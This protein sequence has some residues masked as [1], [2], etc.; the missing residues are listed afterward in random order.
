MS[1]RLSIILIS[2]IA[3]IVCGCAKESCP[4]GIQSDLERLDRAISSRNKYNED[5]QLRID[6]FNSRLAASASPSDQYAGNK[7][8]FDEY[9]KFNPDSA[10]LYVEKCLAIAK[11]NNLAHDY[12]QSLID[13]AMV[14]IYQGDYY[15]AH[16]MLDSIG[17]VENISPVL[18]HKAASAFIEFHIRRAAINSGSGGG[19]SVEE[20]HQYWE[21]FSPYLI[22]G[23]WQTEYYEALMTNNDKRTALKRHIKAMSDNPMV[24]AMLNYA[25][26]L[27]YFRE[28]KDVETMHYIIE[29]AI[30]DIEA[31]NRE[32][33]SLI[34]L[35]NRGLPY[36]DTE[37][38]YK[39]VMI[40][41]E[42]AHYYKDMGRSFNVIAAHASITNDFSEKLKHRSDV[43]T[44]IVLA[45]ITAI[46][47]IV[48][49]FIKF[50]NKRKHEK[51]LLKEKNELT[52]KLQLMVEQGKLLQQDLLKTNRELAQHISSRNKTFLNVYLLVMK[53]VKDVQAFKKDLHSFL[54]VGKYEKAK[55]E[56]A[57]NSG[58]EK[59]LK[60]FYAQFDRAFLMVHPDFPQKFNEL[61]KDENKINLPAPETLTPE[62]RIYALVSL[63]LTDSLS[64]AEFL[65]Y[66]P[67][68][69]YNYRLKVRKGAAIP[70]KSFATTVAHFYQ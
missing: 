25:L 49:L 40:C 11:D 24:C 14:N 52:D 26:A 20:A 66:S 69:I 5:K 42:N 4:E 30:N 34:F 54:V 17:P 16:L 70:E 37:R 53:Y 29:S 32:A 57:S 64:I 63:G 9:L 31:S 45:L 39:Y 56:A 3:F 48:W 43:L 36:I 61:L 35:A 65:H 2:I 55:R 58:L 6:K 28:G 67:Q 1:A 62:L 60:E 21:E 7:H 68:T 51:Q 23:N 12:L 41:T 59:Y 22:N 13:R 44:I 10:F 38:A 27:S 33:Q 47:V 8:L 50:Y 18:Q 46:G 15:K 19:V